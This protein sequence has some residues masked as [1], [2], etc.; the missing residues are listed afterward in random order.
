MAEQPIK[1]RGGS[2]R[3]APEAWFEGRVEFEPVLDTPDI[4]LRQARVHFH[5]G[6]R[7]RWHLHVGDQVL[8][9]VE[10]EGMAEDADGTTVECQAGDIVHVPPGTRH[11]HG[12]VPGASAVHIAITQGDTI[13]EIDEAYPRD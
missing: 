12:A 13:W 7:T 9:F 10:G 2:K 6:A 11:R 1:R 5:D 3:P 8:Y 4:A